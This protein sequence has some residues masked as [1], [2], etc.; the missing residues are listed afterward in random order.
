MKKSW[1]SWLLLSAAMVL[2][3]AAP[4]Y[5]GAQA[6]GNLFK[7]VM[8]RKDGLNWKPAPDGQPP[9]DVCTMLQA[10]SGSTKVLVQTPVTEGGKRIT[11]AMYLTKSMDGKRDAIILE[12]LSPGIEAYFFLLAPDGTM[13][14]AAYDETG[15][16]FMAIGN[17]VGGPAFEQD[18]KIW[19][20]YIAKV[21]I[22]PPAPAAPTQP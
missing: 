2:A 10:C 14:K 4:P 6:K 20:P 17:A 8:D 15:K 5:A 7:D 22:A 9:A 1:L 16:P 18:L 13:S 21:S 12:R 19:E 11:R 3:L